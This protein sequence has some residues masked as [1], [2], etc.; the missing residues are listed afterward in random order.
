VDISV[1]QRLAEASF[2]ANG[3]PT[4]II[5]AH[6]ASILVAFGWQDICLGFHR[7]D[8]RASRRC[9]ESD[10]LV[11][12][13]LSEPEPCEYQ[14]KNGLRHIG[15][16][17]LIAGEHLATM[18]LSQFF[19]E[20]ESPDRQIFVEQAR[21]FGFDDAS[22]LAALARV[23][24]FSRKVVE[25]ILQYNKALVRFLSDLAERSLAHARDEE[26]LREADRRKTEFLAVL[27]HEL[28][29][30]LAPIQHSLWLLDHAR[31]DTRGHTRGDQ[32]QR[33]KETIKRQVI[34]LTRLVDE[35]LDVTRISQ[36]KMNLKKVRI[37]LAAA[38]RR[39]LEDHEPLFAAREVSLGTELPEKAI[40]V[41]ADPTRIAQMVG[42][43]LGN[44]A[45]FSKAGGRATVSVASEGSE[46]ERMAVIRVRDDGMGIPA[47]LLG[48]VFEPFMQADTTLHRSRGGLGLGLSLVKRLVELHGGQVEARSEGPDRGSEFVVRLPRVLEGPVAQDERRLAP[49]GMPRRRVLVIE[50]NVDAADVLREMLLIWDH[51]VEVAR[52]GRE[53][54]LK[55]RSFRPDLVLCDI[56]L[57]GMDGYEVA[58]AIRSDPSIA[59]TYLVAITGYASPDDERK[60]A[61]AGFHRYLPKPVPVDV[62]EDVLLS[63]PSR[64]DRG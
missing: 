11:N 32:C 53:G 29:N 43:L 28:R 14:C 64:R 61:R 31:G 50:D 7:A 2:K 38:V 5:D 4:S 1:V 3:M 18:F 33:A 41:D 42:N 49:D 48:R 24:V 56:G 13:H 35:L 27:S 30:P 16:P 9:R 21:L 44:A 58:E 63:A 57:P 47:G 60:V 45:K 39:T 25:N 36:G 55:A 54:L 59:S 8:P 62:I 40:F 46:G 23:P 37:D 12:G 17:V 52:D 26:A 51:E 22:Y 15:I 6:D 34:H 19:Y 10:D 20:G